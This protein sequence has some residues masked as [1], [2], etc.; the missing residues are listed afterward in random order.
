MYPF[1]AQ[2]L[3]LLRLSIGVWQRRGAAKRS[4]LSYNEPTVTEVF[5]LDLVEFFPGNVL[6]IP[7]TPKR[8]SQVGADWAWAFI[9]PDG[10]SC[11]ALLVQ[12]KRLDD[13]ERE[14]SELYYR[15]PSSGSNPSVPQLDTLISSAKRFGLPP[16]Y[17]FYN[18]LSDRTRVPRNSCRTLGLARS[19]IPESWGV[20]VASAFNVRRARSDKTYSR[21]RQHS[22]PLHCLLCS[23]GTGQQD[24]MG[25][26]GAAATGLSMLFEGMSEDD[27]LG[28][29]LVPPFEPKAGLPELFQ[30]AERILQAR[31]EGDRELFSGLGREFPGIAGAVIVRDPE[32]R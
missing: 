30:N 18:H 19:S 2:Q 7:F 8:E 27:G 25:S 13:Q 15:G 23:R 1:T 20:S 26:A 5:L 9:G 32:D 10:R 6:I 21:H 24:A 4:G 17:A 31:A 3:C 16:V 28:P 29:D 12:A 11:Q 22:L 14:Y